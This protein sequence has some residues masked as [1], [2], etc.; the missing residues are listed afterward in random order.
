[1][2][3]V[4]SALGRAE[5]VVEGQPTKKYFLNHLCVPILELCVVGHEEV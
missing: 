1:M 3:H 4:L 5:K 2:G